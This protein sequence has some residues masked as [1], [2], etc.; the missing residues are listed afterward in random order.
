MRRRA[1]RFLYQTSHFFL[2]FFHSWKQTWLAN[3]AN[4][5][6]VSLEQAAFALRRTKFESVLPATGSSTLLF[7]LARLSSTTKRSTSRASTPRARVAGANW[8]GGFR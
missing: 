8:D 1:E 7:Y 6:L 2:S 3:C 4:P 5:R